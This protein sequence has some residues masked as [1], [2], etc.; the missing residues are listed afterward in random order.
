MK[1]IQIGTSDFKKLIKGNNYFVD[2]SLLIKEFIENGTDII[3]MP[4][5]RGFGKTEI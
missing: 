2:K 5:S 3:L 1:T 4:R